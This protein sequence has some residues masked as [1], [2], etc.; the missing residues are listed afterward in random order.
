MV[1]KTRVF[2][3][4]DITL[5][6]LLGLGK[7][8]RFG[9]DQSLKSL[10]FSIGGN[11]ANFAVI[12]SKLGFK[13]KLVSIL[14]KDFPAPFLRA[15]LAKAHVSSQLVKGRKATSVSIIAVNAKGE[16]AI[17][18]MP[19]CL[20]EL[21]SKQVEKALLPKLRP[22]DIVFFG[23]FYHLPGLRPGFKS[24]LSKIRCKGA[25]ICFDTCFDTYSN[26]NISQFIPFFDLLFVNDL[27]LRHIATGNTLAKRVK[28]LFRKGASVVVVKQEA[29]GASL[30][31]NG[32]TSKRF[33]SVSTKVVDTTGAGDAF[34][35]GFVF[36]L[37]Q[38][39]SLE[40][41]TRAGNF[42]AAKQIRQHGLA[43]PSASQ[44]KKFV[45]RAVR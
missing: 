31:V 42:V 38:G 7:Q 6:V 19:G 33:P 28:H 30:F 25:V 37:L 12:G 44:V 18:S 39:F 27:E 4:G 8:A 22:L 2:A 11:A 24:L 35:A 9:Q 23:A 36:G 5:D 29:K 21:T 16:R 15:E 1:R 43:A 13:P 14:G 20:T 26:W 3:V 40:Q 17:H 10:V 45:R 41:C 32:Q 34:N